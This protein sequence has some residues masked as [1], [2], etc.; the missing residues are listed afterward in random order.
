MGPIA[1]DHVQTLP[2]FCILLYHYCVILDDCQNRHFQV[3][4]HNVFTGVYNEYTDITSLSA[5]VWKVYSYNKTC[6]VW[7][8][9]MNL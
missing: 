6:I 3:L 8:M 9:I 1:I 7:L 4:S 5:T 2:I